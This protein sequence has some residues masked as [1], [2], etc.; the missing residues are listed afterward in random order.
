M[1]IIENT[2]TGTRINGC[3]SV[4]K[5][6]SLSIVSCCGWGEL[7]VDKTISLVFEQRNTSRN[8]QNGTEVGV[9]LLFATAAQKDRRQLP[10]TLC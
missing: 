4:S 6:V 3:L 8:W 2:V 9:G 7:E 10:S 5:F 1:V